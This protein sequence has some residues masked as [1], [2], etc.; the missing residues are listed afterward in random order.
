MNFVKLRLLVWLVVTLPSTVAAQQNHYKFT[1]LDVKQGLSNSRAKCFLKDRK[2]FIWIGTVSGLNRFDGYAIKTFRNDVRDTTSLIDSDIKSLFEDPNGKM[3]VDT[4]TGQN[5]YDPETETFIRNSNEL[6]TQ[7][8]IPPGKIINIEKGKGLHYWFLHATVGLFKYFPEERRTVKIQHNAADTTTLISDNLSAAKEDK[9]GNLWIIHSNGVFELMSGKTH[10][11][12]YRS[13]ALNKKYAGQVLDYNLMIDTEG[14]TWIFIN[15]N[16]K[17]VHLFKARERSFV[18]INKTTKPL[19]LNSDIVR[20]IVQDDNGIIWVG[21][22]H[23]GINLINKKNKTTDYIFHNAEDER[24]L[25]QNSIN[26]LYKDREGFIWAGTMKTG[27]SYYHEN[28][29]RFKLL[30]HLDSNPLSLPYNDINALAEDKTGNLWIG[31]NG[32]GLIYYNRKDET[33]TQYKNKPGVA[34]S[35]SNNVIVSLCVDHD[36]NVWIGTYFGGLNLYDGK[37]FVRYKHN[38]KIPES[39]GDDNIWEIF[40]DTQRRLWIGTLESGVDF[41]DRNKNEFKHYPNDGTN[42]LH[43]SYVPAIAE[44]REGN[45]WFGTGYGID[46][47]NKQ[48]NRFTHYLNIAKDTTS[49]SDNGVMCLLNDSRGNM[50]IGTKEGLNL[51][52]KKSNRFQVFREKEGLPHNSIITL[53]EDNY[54]NLWL[55]TANG[56]SNMILDRGQNGDILSYTFRNYN[57]SDGLQGKQ[58]NEGAACR[59]AR[60]ELVFGGTNGIN[61]FRPEDV[62]LNTI[63][64]AVVLSDFQI[65]NKS[66]R[67]GEDVDG[68]TILTKAISATSEITLKH[69]DNVFSIEFAA[70]NFLHSEKSQYKYM[71]KGF[72]KDWL[73]TDGASRKVTYTNLDPGEYTFIVKSAN[74]DGVWGENGAE[75]KIVILPPFWKTNTAF[76]IYILGVLG[77]LLLSRQLILERERLKYKMD[78][79]RQEALQLHELDVMKIKFFTNVSHEFRTPLSLILIP[80]EKILKQTSNTDQ[81]DQ[82]QMMHRNARRLL[83]LVNQL[84]DLRRMEVQQVKLNPSEGDIISFIKET[85]NS[86]SDLSEKNNIDFSIRSSVNTLETVF[87]KDKL[88]K[89]LFNLL[90]NAFKFTPDHGTVTVEIKR[91]EKSNEPS[92]F[93]EIKVIDTGIGIPVEKQDKIFE[94][95]FQHDLPKSMVNQGS[96]IGLSI[97]YEF[98]KAHNGSITVESEPD[99]GS[100]FTVLLPVQKLTGTVSKEQ[101]LDEDILLKQAS[102]VVTDEENLSRSNSK[103]PVLLLVEDNEDFRFYLK[104]NLKTNYSIIEARNGREGLEKTQQY[105]PDLIVSD[106]MMPEMN[107]IELCRKVKEEK[108]LSHIPVI[109]LT[110]RTSEEQRLEGFET[111]ADD[112]I[113]KPFNFEILQS[114]IKNLIHQREL[115]HKDF[116]KQIE[117]KA[118]A[119]KITSLDENLIQNA[120]K[121]VED[122]IGNPDFSVEHLSHELGM[123]RVHLYK[124]LLSLTGKAPLE[125]IRTIRI[126]RAAQFLEKSQLTVAEVAYKVG[127]NN[128]K[129]FTKYFKDEYNILPSAY[130]A[131]KRKQND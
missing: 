105:L 130:A 43:A 103:L 91:I 24:S 20:G 38:A 90:S 76:V 93:I 79:E 86:F 53:L 92:T 87:D 74:N 96:G 31:T 9:N 11:I 3:W 32:E 69:S 67:I 39:L 4:W 41:F 48:S 84:L 97:T 120:I 85:A 26:A 81:R 125:F 47:L 118:S 112:Y 129:Y 106:V 56:L 104:D 52:D 119:V 35:L 10:K 58:F 64:P 60:G 42:S 83:N 72:N 95:F 57:E 126:Q 131:G 5:V 15:N 16:N 8:N 45:I 115:F 7:F 128:P 33:F 17:G 14:D 121:L 77:A 102:E 34:N 110:A 117:V 109:L 44:D 107:G 71:L 27:V 116:R 70:L 61:I 46:V 80:L 108:T 82:F 68:R 111:G 1:Q 12:I 49:L 37:R 50:W 30:K 98:V 65:F 75:L 23:G 101:N 55:G 124:K 25:G 127:F 114:R 100:V 36:D 29:L 54:N 19:R 94:R 78:K 66:V 88:E 18:H 28:F 40:E 62:V 2:G 99:K 59:T 22:D 122:N 89:I 21:T 113:T 123:S 6:L 51:F 13:Y 63:K 73:T